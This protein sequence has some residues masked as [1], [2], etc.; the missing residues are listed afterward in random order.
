MNNL[1]FL[2]MDLPKE[3]EKLVTRHTVTD[4][5]T[6]NE[7]H[8]YWL[9]MINTIGALKALLEDDEIVVHIPNVDFPTEMDLEELMRNI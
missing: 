4:G 6:D 2:A 5:M 3:T 9:G 8:A 7:K 1:L